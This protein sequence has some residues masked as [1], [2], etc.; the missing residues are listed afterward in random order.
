MSWKLETALMELDFNQSW[1]AT[2][3]DLR[4]EALAGV[5]QAITFMGGVE[6][7][8]IVIALVFCLI[9]KRLAVSAAIVVLVSMIANHLLKTLVQ[10]PRPFVED[11][12]YLEN[13][14]VSPARA[15]ELVAEFSTPSGH[16]M[17]AAAFYGFLL[18]NTKH[19]MSRMILLMI[20]FLIGMSR[21]VLGVHYFEDIAIG[22][23][24]GGG[25]ALLSAYKLNDLWARWLSLNPFLQAMLVLFTSGLVWYATLVLTGRSPAE[26]PTEFVSVLGFL[27]GVLVA[28]PIELRRVNYDIQGRALI[29]A[30][31][32]FALMLFILVLT[33]LATELPALLMGEPSG[34]VESV[35]R[36]ISYGLVAAVGVLFVPWIFIRF[37]LATIGPDIGP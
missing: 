1:L 13:W 36:Y 19:L 10:N 22:W 7:Y 4:T 17:A 34:V 20:P 23:L 30:T 37:K 28:A 15:T 25:I 35:W 12:T 2:V 8:L 16:A 32:R 33:L 14:E 5:F 6:G 9:G 27:S 21:P 24:L 26:L 3:A 11:G 18:A 29:P 31:I